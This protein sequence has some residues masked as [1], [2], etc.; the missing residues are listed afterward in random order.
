MITTPVFWLLISASRR[1]AGLLEVDLKGV[2][3]A[4]VRAAPCPFRGLELAVGAR[5]GDD[6][7]LAE[8]QRFFEFRRSQTERSPAQL[9]I[10]E[11]LVHIGEILIPP[12]H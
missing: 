7:L 9:D 1:S 3:L 4:A 5:I 2:P 6:D 12:I 8:P 10:A 11:Q